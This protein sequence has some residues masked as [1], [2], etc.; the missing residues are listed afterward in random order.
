MGN[1]LGSAWK[2]SPVPQRR[3]SPR[4]GQL[5]GVGWQNDVHGDR[6]LRLLGPLLPAP[7]VLWA[8]LEMT[9]LP[10]HVHAAVFDK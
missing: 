4:G 7:I 1:Q 9:P 8:L 10:A 6:G 2:Q 3:G 5:E